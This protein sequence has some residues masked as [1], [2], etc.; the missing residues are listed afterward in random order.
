MQLH[1]LK[2]L[3]L[4]E[5][6]RAMNRTEDAVAGLIRRGLKALRTMLQEGE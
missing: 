3:S 4:D 1:H 2:K 5:T 6:A